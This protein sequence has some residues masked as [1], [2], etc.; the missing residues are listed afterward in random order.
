M[1]RL[2]PCGT[3]R[4]IR[5]FYVRM[6]TI[7]LTQG[8]SAIVDDEDFEI[9]NSLAWQVVIPRDIA[10]AQGAFRMS[11]G[12][13]KNIRMHRLILNAKPGTQIDHINRNALDNRRC[14][15]RFCTRSQNQCN[16]V[17]DKRRHSSQY[18]G[19]YWD[20]Q[21]E[22][23]RAQ[24]FARRKTFYLGCFEREE[25]AARAYD[26]AAMSYYGTFVRPNFPCAD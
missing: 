23:W 24:F 19:V 12:R 9:L 2:A 22:L 26:K 21:L 5:M 10:Y 15:L 20:K 7:A 16:R 13:I 17:Y 11:D 18:R 4:N 14:N 1:K 3:R 6:K 25:D 8:Y